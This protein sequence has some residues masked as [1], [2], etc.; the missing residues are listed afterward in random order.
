M[1][2]WPAYPFCSDVLSDP[3]AEYERQRDAKVAEGLTRQEATTELMKE[4][5]ALLC[6]YL[7]A[8][9]RQRRRPFD[10]EARLRDHPSKAE[11]CQP[12]YFQK[13]GKLVAYYIPTEDDLETIHG[14]FPEM[15][16]EQPEWDV[17]RS[18][19]RRE[20]GDVKDWSVREILEEL[21]SPRGVAVDGESR[22][23]HDVLP[24]LMQLYRDGKDWP[25]YRKMAEELNCR[26]DAPVRNAVKNASVEIQEWANPPKKGSSRLLAA[27]E[28]FDIAVDTKPQTSESDPSAVALDDELDLLLAQCMDA[29]DAPDED[30]EKWSAKPRDE[31]RALVETYLASKVERDEQD[32]RHHKATKKS[33]LK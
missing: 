15:D 11:M 3:I 22:R 33:R 9:N 25:G 14:A 23:W 20:H 29:V 16:P 31:Q 17:I 32:E 6:E 27:P 26:S 13:A 1:A 18:K 21:K 4:N 10:R 30:R 5:V 19:L 2:Y 7:S 8:Y 12:G 28:A 24:E